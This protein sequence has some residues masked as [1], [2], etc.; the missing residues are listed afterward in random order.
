MV[1][2]IRIGEHGYAHG[3]R[4]GRRADRARRPR[5]EGARRAVAQHERPPL[6]RRRR[7]A[8]DA[9]PVS[10]EYMDEDGRNEL[11]VAAR[12]AQLGWTVIVEQPT[13]EAYA[14][15][16][17]SSASWSWR[18]RSRSLVMISVGYLFGRTSSRRSSTLQRGT[19]D[20][21]AGQLDARVDIRTRRRVRRPRRRVQHHG[22]PPGRAA[23]RT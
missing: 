16:T 3:R 1:D 14:N 22:Q 7:G 4:P 6:V 11:G 12:I 5:Q 8:R 21:A 13:R 18:S 9:A 10:Q 23:G 2:Q 15:A 17:R 20:V 19:H